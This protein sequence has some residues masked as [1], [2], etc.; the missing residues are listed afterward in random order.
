[1]P[2]WVADREARNHVGALNVLAEAV[3]A[4]TEYSSIDTDVVIAIAT[5]AT[6]FAGGAVTLGGKL[7]ADAGRT[8]AASA[9]KT[10]ASA[11]G[12]AGLAL[13]VA[14]LGLLAN[15]FAEYGEALEEVRFG[16]GLVGI[17][18]DARLK[19][20]RE[21]AEN[22]AFGLKIGAAAVA[23][24][25][26][27]SGAQIARASRAPTVTA[28]TDGAAATPSVPNAPTRVDTPRDATP[29]PR[30]TGGMF[31]RPDFRDLPD[32][33]PAEAPDLEPWMTA[34]E[35]AAAAA[36]PAPTT[37]AGTDTSAATVV[38]T[39]RTPRAATDT[40]VSARPAN[41]DGDYTIDLGKPGALD[42]I[43]RRIE[44]VR[45]QPEGTT[46]GSEG[47]LLNRPP[48]RDLPG[49]PPSEPPDLGPWMTAEERAAAERAARA[50]EATR[51]DAVQRSTTN[52]PDDAA[53]ARPRDDADAED[54]LAGPDEDTTIVPELQRD[55]NTAG[56][57]EAPRGRPA[58]EAEDR[59]AG[60]NEDTTIVPELQ[61]D[62]S[63]TPEVEDRLAGPN[64]DTTIVPELQ[65]DTGTGSDIARMSTSNDPPPRAEEFDPN[66]PIEGFEDAPPTPP[67]DPRRD[68]ER[69]L[70]AREARVRARNE[71][72]LAD[73][74]LLRA[75]IEEA[76]KLGR[77]EDA[78]GIEGITAPPMR[79]PNDGAR[80]HRKLI[81]GD[82]EYLDNIINGWMTRP[83]RRTP[84]L[85]PRLSVSP[86]R[87]PPLPEGPRPVGPLYRSQTK[88][89]AHLVNDYVEQILREGRLLPS[90]S[91]M[92]VLLS[93]DV[94]FIG[95]SGHHRLIAAVIAS[96]LTGRPLYGGPNAI[97]AD[98]AIVFIDASKSP[99]NPGGGWSLGVT[100]PIEGLDGAIAKRA[101][102]IRQ[103]SEAL[104]AQASEAAQAGDPA[105]AQRLTRQA[106]HLDWQLASEVPPPE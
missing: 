78:P 60:P 24:A 28:P 48:F 81:P 52:P 1:V 97:I 17:A 94:D 36:R 92:E 11:A 65:R 76:E 12:W 106:D 2:R 26:I 72:E 6:I 79:N 39:A 57:G 46:P 16:E 84:S 20:A 34:D 68:L 90:E 21:D 8:A 80:P 71:A 45:Q 18:G 44:L 5:S 23:G 3:K 55:A 103:Q 38:D 58:P 88:V 73:A 4:Q 25:G 56:R 98:D 50:N 15:D 42:E 10:T 64:E 32:K 99:L 31:D 104:R 49:K 41:A 59:L 62:R 43:R 19:E 13:D 7:A 30:M 74:K 9:L 37:T 33:P 66:D 101:A 54:R 82:S 14:D 67:R 29:S 27:A 102:R 35:R 75:R 83:K 89:A 70:A 63:P 105:R 51:A 100:A 85:G 96:R 91:P 87:L 61:R 22:R 40:A 93:P 86:D 69:E 77:F 53:P 95:K 47:D